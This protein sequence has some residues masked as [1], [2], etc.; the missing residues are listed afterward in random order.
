MSGF[1][2]AGARS[3]ISVGCESAALEEDVR[4]FVGGRE[5]SFADEDK[6]EQ[7]HSSS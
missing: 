6:F 7:D 1:Q 5:F 3:H 2:I 4:V